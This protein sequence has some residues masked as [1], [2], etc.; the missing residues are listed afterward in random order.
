MLSYNQLHEK[1]LY[2][3]TLTRVLNWV[4]RR[5]SYHEVIQNHPPTSPSRAWNAHLLYLT[6]LFAIVYPMLSAYGQWVAGDAPRLGDVTI[7]DTTTPFVRIITL[8]LLIIIFMCLYFLNYYTRIKSW[9][10]FPVFLAVL[11]L[12]IG[13]IS[14]FGDAGATLFGYAISIFVLGAVASALA[15]ALLEHR[16]IGPSV[17]LRLSFIL[18]L[19]AILSIVIGW[20]WRPDNTSSEQS[21]VLFF[22]IL[23]VLNGE[24]DFASIGLTRFCLR[25]G[26]NGRAIVWGIVDVVGGFVIFAILGVSI[27]AYVHYVQTPNGPLITLE[28]LFDGLHSTP[29]EYIWVMV[30]FGS[31][32]LPTLLHFI[33][34]LIAGGYLLIPHIPPL[35]KGLQSSASI[36]HMLALF[37][38]ILF[39]VMCFYVPYAAITWI[40]G[41]YDHAILFWVLSIFEE[42]ARGIGAISPTWSPQVV[43]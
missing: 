25:Q 24:S 35:Y 42:F 30:M 9:V 5:V 43:L 6:L 7:A 14:T 15:V 23:P 3:A 1:T 40:L 12:L 22:V 33:L 21:V 38:V 39:W 11:M 20:F 31:T 2:R 41:A 26:L 18:I 4:D 29:R 16:K 27:I 34:I 19:F 13:L 36:P 8:A 32:L 10:R 28:T 37:F 17:V